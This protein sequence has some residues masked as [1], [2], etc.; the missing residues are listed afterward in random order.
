MKSTRSLDLKCMQLSRAINIVAKQATGI[1]ACAGFK[2]T[3]KYVSKDKKTLTNPEGQKKNVLTAAQI[4]AVLEYGSPLRNIPSRPFMSNA[5][6]KQYGAQLT[7]ITKK[8]LA[9]L[10]RQ[11]IQ[12]LWTY[13]NMNPAIHSKRAVKA[14]ADELATAMYDNI[15][16]EIDNGTFEPLAGW[17]ARRRKKEKFLDKSDDFIK[18]IKAWTVTEKRNGI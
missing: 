8:H 4:A 14:M 16:K 11:E 7:N 10:F 2:D 6:R 1:I 17:Y 18:L 15:K 5:I 3:D 13:S 9:H 12:D